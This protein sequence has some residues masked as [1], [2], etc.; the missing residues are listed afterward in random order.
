M[1]IVFRLVLLR[2]CK[3]RALWLELKE[4]PESPTFDDT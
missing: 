1:L 4:A 2:C 3:V